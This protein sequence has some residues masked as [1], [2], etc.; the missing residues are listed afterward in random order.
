MEKT[1]YLSRRIFLLFFLLSIL[2]ISGNI[3]AIEFSA[4]NRNEIRGDSK[5]LGIRFQARVFQGAFTETIIEFNGKRVIVQ[6]INGDE[7]NAIRI[8]GA[9]LK[10]GEAAIATEVDAQYLEE[11]LA[12]LSTTD[13]GRNKPG[14]MLVRTLNL[15]SSW[16]TGQPIALMDALGGFIIFN[17]YSVAYGPCDW[18]PDLGVSPDICTDMNQEHQ[19][20]Y[21]SFGLYT[22][23]DFWG[24]VPIYYPLRCTQFTAV[25]GPYPYDLGDCMGRCGVGCSAIFPGSVYSQDC[26]NHDMC[27][28]ELGLTHPY[29]N[30][31]FILCID[32]FLFGPACEP[33]L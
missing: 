2:V 23:F 16:P 33:S 25:V 13:I 32:D 14:E 27:V 28:G 30:Q 12:K 29:C 15:L 18:P 9:T 20:E 11:L 17:K 8:N 22:G 10:T 26:F 31:M 24:I 19:G 1:L 7:A 4:K 3:Y 6:A 5:E 21:L